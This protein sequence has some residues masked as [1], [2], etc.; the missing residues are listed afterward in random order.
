MCEYAET[1]VSVRTNINRICGCDENE[2]VAPLLL[3]IYE[4]A[5]NNVHKKSNRHDHTVK[6]FALTLLIL[7]GKA[8]YELLQKNLKDALPAYSSLQRLMGTKE[9]MVEGTFYFIELVDHLNEWKAS[10][11]VHVQL[12]DTRII[13]QVVYDQFTDRFVGFIL[14]LLDGLPICDTFVFHT[15]EELQR[16]YQEHKDSIAKYAHCI[17]VQSV[18]V[19]VPSFVLSVL[20]TDSKYDNVVVSKRWQ[21]MERELGKVGVTVIS[22]GSDG[23]GPFL[24]AMLVETKLF[25]VSNIYNVPNSWKFFMMPLIKENGLCV[26]DHV[27]LLAKLRSR[28]LAPSNLIVLGAETACP[29]HLRKVVNDV[30][31]ERHGL[32]KKDINNKDKQNYHSIAILVGD[33]LKECLLELTG[34][35][36]PTGTIAYLGL[37]RKLR[38]AFF[39]KAMT[40]IDRVA[41][42]WEVVFFV[43]IWRCWLSE[44]G[45]SETIHF[46][47]TNAYTCIELNAHFLVNLLFNVINGGF[48]KEVLRVWFSGS[49]ACEQLFRLVRSMTPFFFNHH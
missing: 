29:S 27:H 39:E 24:K 4:N 18:E 43:R 36:R 46:V 25:S 32:T 12:D 48:P 1:N 13:N 7:T 44:N 37:M 49:Q 45:Y 5:K 28:L 38:D 8:G 6:K 9:R 10:K 21:Y 17:V 11:F 16:A 20:G 31:K 23:A 3:R 2:G 19:E 47:T 40:P 33:D 15:F 26:Q 34:P 30:P 22:Y 41:R 14:P 35:I 42:L